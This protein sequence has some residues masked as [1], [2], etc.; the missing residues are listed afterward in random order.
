MQ[1]QSLALLAIIA[2]LALAI[3]GCNRG[4][5]GVKVTG[6][7]T[8][9]GKAQDG[10]AVAFLPTDGS[11]QSSKGARTDSEGKFEL[12]L[13]PGNYTV[14]LVRMVD[15]KGNAPKESEDPSQDSTQ[16]EASGY[17]SNAY[18]AKY[19]EPSKSPFKVE[20]P[21]GGKELAPFEV[22]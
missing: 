20:I 19:S 10:V 14:T 12:K 22:K 5:P 4:V 11:G 21:A 18:D 6:S 15:R 13:L 3:N 2:A 8:K 9:G 16:L 1:R 7:V 17:L